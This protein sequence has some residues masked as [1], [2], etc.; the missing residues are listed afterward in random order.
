MLTRSC[1]AKRVARSG[2]EWNDGAMSPS[3]CC[4]RLTG[5]GLLLFAVACAPAVTEPHAK[6]P[7]APAATEATGDEPVPAPAPVVAPKVP[8]PAP[9]APAAVPDPAPQAAPY[10]LAR[11][12][13]DKSDLELQA[14]DRAFDGDDLKAAKAHY[15]KA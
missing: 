7:P 15:A 11:G 12:T 10:G 1:M 5:L 13:G 8:E 3:A 14:A 6:A 2:S 4:S 9:T